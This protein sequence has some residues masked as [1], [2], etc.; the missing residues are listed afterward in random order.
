MPKPISPID[1]RLIDDLF[2]M[3]GGYVLDF[4]NRTFAEFFQSELGVNIDLPRFEREGTS[5]AK[6]LRYFLK[7][8]DPKTRGRTL[9]ALWKYRE[10]VRR[11]NGEPERTPNAASLFQEVLARV[12]GRP[13]PKRPSPDPGGKPSRN[14]QEDPQ[15]K[16][17]KTVLTGL[18]NSLLELSGLDPQ[19]RGFAFEKFLKKVFD[20]HGL[21]GRASFRNVGEQIDGS[22]EMRGETYLLEAKWQNAQVGASDL[23][24]FNGNVEEKAAWSRGLFVSMSGFSPDGLVAYGRAKRII[25]MDGLDLHELL[26]RSIPFSEVVARKVRRAA[27]SGEPFVQVR[28][29]FP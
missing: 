3:G 11:M 18:R 1:M 8:S 17:D 16:A 9:R 12:E 23:R 21:G 27:E 15:P 24:A 13:P 5:K 2:D 29:L 4:S 10:A 26:E 6:R 20:A 14:A 22:F 7:V 28:A 19:T 25:C